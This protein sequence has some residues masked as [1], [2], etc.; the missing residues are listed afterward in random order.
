L[1]RF[2]RKGLK[3][4]MQHL[5]LLHGAIGGS[6]QLAPLAEKLKKQFVVHNLNFP[7]HGG[8]ALPSHFSISG[9]AEFVKQ[10]CD[11]Q[12]IQQACF[13]GYSMGGYVAM[14]LASRYPGLTLKIVTLATKFHWD[15]ETAS[16]EVNMLQPE[17]I[18]QKLPQFA[19][20]LRQRHAPNDWKEVL[21]KTGSM[22]VEMG[23]DSPLK[24]EDLA[25]LDFPCL[26]MLGDRDKMVTLEETLDVYKRLPDGQLAVLPATPHPIEGVGAE[27]LLFMLRRFLG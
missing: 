20:T 4:L 5:I 8:S 22:L 10:Y 25:M 13:F 23:T 1:V 3:L 19:E 18:E 21:K 27:T 11:R 17:K 15:E 26:V 7:G 6:E 24:R 9:F 14:Y 12:N 2:G 16:K